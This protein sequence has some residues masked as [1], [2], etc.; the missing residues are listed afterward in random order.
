MA[1]WIYTLHNHKDLHKYKQMQ[2]QSSCALGIDKCEHDK[3]EI[4]FTVNTIFIGITMG[5]WNCLNILNIDLL[6]IL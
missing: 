1:H 3:N 4:L 5:Y 2:F 6:K